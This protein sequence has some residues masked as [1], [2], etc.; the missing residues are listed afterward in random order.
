M[1]ISCQERCS[2]TQWLA[3][4]KCPDCFGVE[5]NLE[6]GETCNC[7]LKIKQGLEKRWK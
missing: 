7:K 4:I 5:V 6:E 3:N 2:F 1:K